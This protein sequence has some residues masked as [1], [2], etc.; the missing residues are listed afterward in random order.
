[1]ETRRFVR[2]LAPSLISSALAAFI[3]AVVG[4]WITHSIVTQDTRSAL[5]ATAYSAY[6]P[7]ATRIVPMAIQGTLNPKDALRLEE[8][9]SVLIM[10]ASDEVQCRAL[11][12][13]QKIGKGAVDGQAEYFDLVFAMK[14]EVLGRK[15][16]R[17]SP[18]EKC[19]W[20]KF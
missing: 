4:G 13:V 16:E 7:E 15:V 20:H 8:A 6:L 10:Y 1:M 9:T 11:K 19:E 2:L 17:P 5:V 3:G 12:F 18:P 14:E